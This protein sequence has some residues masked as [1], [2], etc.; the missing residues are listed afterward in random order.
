M[1]PPK[2]YMYVNPM[3]MPTREITSVSVAL[4]PRVRSPTCA[5]LGRILFVDAR[6][7]R[8]VDEP[9]KKRIKVATKQTTKFRRLW[10]LLVSVDNLAWVQISIDGRYLGKLVPRSGAAS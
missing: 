10:E 7:G 2:K 9:M 8:T 5:F 6:M 3:G 4:K 1:T